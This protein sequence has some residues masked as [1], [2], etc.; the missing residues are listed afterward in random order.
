MGEGKKK[1]PKGWVTIK[2]GELMF[3]TP[4][5]NPANRPTNKYE[6]WSVPAFP[7]DVPE[8]VQGKDIGS[9][10]QMVKTGD[11][12]LCKINP[13]I[14]RV[15]LV[16]DKTDFDQIASTEWIVLR[17]NELLP[18]FVMYLLREEGFRQRLCADLSGI[19]GSLT[20]ARPRIVGKLEIDLFPLNE[21]KRIVAKIEELQARSRRARE[22]LES[23][24]DLLEQ[25]RQSILASAFRG[26]LTKEW[27]EER[28]LPA[29]RPGV[30]FV[31][32]LKCVDDS[33]YIG[34]TENLQRRWEEHKSGKGGRWTKQNPSQY[35]LHWEEHL[36]RQAAAKR[37]K[38]LKTGFGRKWIKREEK[39]GKLR[40]A[41]N[42]EPAS[43]LLKRI[44]IERRKRWEAAELDKLK[45]KGLTSD[46]LDAAF[47]KQRK[48]YKEPVPV[49]T[50][51]LPE[52][53]EGWCWS[54]VEKLSLLVTKGSSPKWQGFEYATKGV[55]FVRSQNVLSG[56]LD[57]TELAFLPKSFNKKERKSI[58]STNDVLTNIVGASIGRAA[59]ATE[60]V[61]GGNVNQAVAVIR[62]IQEGFSPSLLVDWFL[63]PM[64]QSQIH[65]GKV[66]V[67]RANLSLTDVN[68]I[69]L[70]L[71]PFVEQE[72]LILQLFRS[73][74]LHARLSD[75]ILEIQTWLDDLDLSTLKKASLGELVPQDANDEPASVLLERIREEKEREAAKQRSTVKRRGRI[76]KKKRD[77]QKNVLVVLREASRAMS[78]EEVFAAGGFEEDSVDAFYEQLRKAVV[79][80]QVHEMREGDLIQ[81]E[82]IGK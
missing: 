19:G 5:V 79:S 11:V 73:M 12:L 33:N 26:D 66:E 39:A 2:V 6:L 60:D 45:A 34:I 28:S 3:K 64:G 18:E 46:K 41:G 14:N 37:E 23:V 50:S 8:Y 24:P 55:P 62:L 80:K 20:R 63:S 51:D 68:K 59:L 29:P 16:R 49:D 30:F 77:K 4:S 31:Y 35:V 27:R 75:K 21:Q 69:I 57:L 67:A 1:L 71:P 81:L 72:E 56:S 17:C 13:R 10:K 9:N 48:K 47:A 52:L 53:P 44:R 32:I 82:A 70:P 78:P 15:W 36:S 42:V 61:A 76:M 65:G 22:A 74:R 7:G 54:S 58:L 25:L 43:E 38:W 40:Q